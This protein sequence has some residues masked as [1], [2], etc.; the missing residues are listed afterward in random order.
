LEL[1]CKKFR[2][3]T[4]TAYDEKQN[5]FNKKTITTHDQNQITFN[6]TTTKSYI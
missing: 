1:E 2:A 4:T 6:N 3:I 5:T